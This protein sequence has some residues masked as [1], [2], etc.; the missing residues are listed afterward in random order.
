MTIDSTLVLLVLQFRVVVKC[1][2]INKYRYR[3]RDMDIHRLRH[4]MI[5]DWVRLFPLTPHD[6]HIWTY[7]HH[8]SAA[9][10]PVSCGFQY[11]SWSGTRNW[12]PAQD[13]NG[14]SS[15]VHS[16]PNRK[17]IQHHANISLKSQAYQISFQ[18]KRIQKIMESYNLIGTQLY[19]FIPG[20]ETPSFHHFILQSFSKKADYTTSTCHVIERKLGCSSNEKNKNA[21]WMSPK[22]VGQVTKDR[23]H[24]E[25]FFLANSHQGIT[26]TIPTGQWM[27]SW[28]PIS[29]WGSTCFTCHPRHFFPSPFGSISAGFPSSTSRTVEVWNEWVGD[30]SWRNHP[31]DLKP[32]S[33]LEPTS[34]VI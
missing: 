11:M 23:T 21:H 16:Q 3:Y 10:A 22:K 4:Y 9:S 34:A 17:S 32:K 31:G 14:T 13:R 12:H 26:P 19:P 28:I 1:I 27:D 5:I 20:G 18:P 30:W 7:H 2:S 33:G 6:I 15:A 29:S 8:K 24:V 25:T